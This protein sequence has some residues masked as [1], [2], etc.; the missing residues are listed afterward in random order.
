VSA[1]LAA[2][3]RRGTLAGARRV[4][5]GDLPDAGPHSLTNLLYGA[6][7]L[8]AD[9]LVW[10][11]QAV[12]PSL[13]QEWVTFKGGDLRLQL[14]LDGDAVGLASPQLDWRDYS[15]DTQ[16]IAWTVTHE[17]LIALLRAVFQRD[18]VPECIDDCDAPLGASR[19]RVG[20][21]VSG[22]DGPRVIAGLVILEAATVSALAEAAALSPPRRQ[23][24]RSD[25]HARFQLHLDD[26]EILAQ[27]IPC[28]ERGSIVRLD[29]RTLA[30]SRARIAIVA[31]A[32]RLIADVTG[33]R[34]TVAGFAPAL[35]PLNDEDTNSGDFR[36]SNID[37]TADPRVTADALPVRLTFC[38]GTVTLPFGHVADLAPGY[39]FELDKQ[40]DDKVISVLANDVPIATG[41]LV[42]I[43]DL[44]GVRITRMLPRA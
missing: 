4:E 27:E 14:A 20:F 28:I 40:L 21:A 29:N 19:I 36:M 23:P 43:G 15:G 34:A 39:V 42:T 3:A 18:L 8:Q 6:R 41:E 35:H 2:D 22:A 37:A 13:I 7:A 12:N 1:Q 9:G 17:P 5:Q 25:I 44:V 26:V 24:A 30:T 11:W 31:G 10:H 33:T 32:A 38:A 16:L